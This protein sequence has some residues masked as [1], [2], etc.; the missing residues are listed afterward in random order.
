MRT[1]VKILLTV[2]VLAA[3]VVGGYY[4]YGRYYQGEDNNEPSY[5]VNQQNHKIIIKMYLGK[6]YRQYPLPC[7]N[8]GY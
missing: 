7:R 4:L 1:F 8:Q 2:G 5:D 6:E 3:L